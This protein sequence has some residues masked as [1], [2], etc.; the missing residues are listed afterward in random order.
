[1]NN[2][3][4]TYFEFFNDEVPMYEQYG[5]MHCYFP[6]ISYVNE[7]CINIAV[8]MYD[9]DAS[10][11]QKTLES[12]GN[13]ISRCR[14]KVRVV[15][16]QD[17]WCRAHPSIRDYFQNMLF[18]KSFT[19]WDQLELATNLNHKRTYIIQPLDE[20]TGELNT[21][22]VS[23]SIYLPLTLVIKTNNRQKHNSQAWFFRAFCKD[24]YSH[25]LFLTD[26]G[27]VHHPDCLSRLEVFMDQND[28]LVG[29][30]GYP[31]IAEVQPHS[32]WV[33][34]YIRSMQEYELGPLATDHDRGFQSM[35]GFQQTL[36]GPCTLLRSEDA[37]FPSLLSFMSNVL[38]RSPSQLNVLSSNLNIVEDT[39]LTLYLFATSG[40]M[41][42]LVPDA[43]YYYDVET[44]PR[45][46]FTQRR[47]WMNGV[48][49]GLLLF[50]KTYHKVLHRSEHSKWIQLFIRT[51][52][53]IGILSQVIFPFVQPLL[54]TYVIFQS[55]NPDFCSAYHHCLR[56]FQEKVLRPHTPWLSP[57]MSAIYALWFIIWMLFHA[58]SKDAFNNHIFG[59]TFLISHTIGLYSYYSILVVTM[60]VALMLIP[61]WQRPIVATLI[62]TH[63]IAPIMCSIIKRDWR[64]LK[65]STLGI[66]PYTLFFP[67]WS[68]MYGYNIA[69]IWDVT[70]GNRVG[71]LNQQEDVQKKVIEYKKLSYRIT[72][73]YA[74]V[75]LIGA[76]GLSYSSL[77]YDASYLHAVYVAPWYLLSSIMGIVSIAWTGRYIIYRGKIR[78]VSG[79]TE[80]EEEG[81]VYVVKS[82]PSIFRQ[83]TIKRLQRA[84]TFGTNRTALIPN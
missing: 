34:R 19:S 16:I 81:S 54:F 66:I 32:T 51:L 42:A 39:A 63:Y 11:L 33:Q 17:G 14:R 45:R 75:M 4:E 40:K 83:R 8:T 18:P 64:T 27:T 82:S 80:G 24:Y 48:G 53:A 77:S 55:F 62:L 76:G 58:H 29:C 23:Q 22:W 49:C 50:W 43:Y 44:Q 61:F 7:D 9:E 38:E 74:M 56:G 37:T 52:L 31:W 25:Y 12:I 65:S 67:M 71:I 1:M 13:M 69:R 79:K 36:S 26:V 60:Q 6:A 68:F 10:D 72:Y 47:R 15:V 84:F 3:K 57:S 46:F 70:W 2:H 78:R 73:I 41:L 20:Y 35:F 28:G 5:E 59:I 21:T 30:H